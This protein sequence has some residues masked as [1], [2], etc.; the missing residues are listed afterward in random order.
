MRSHNSY[1]CKHRKIWQI[2]LHAKHTISVMVF[3]RQVLFQYCCFS[4]KHSF[5]ARNTPISSFQMFLWHFKPQKLLLLFDLDHQN[6]QMISFLKNTVSLQCKASTQV[7][8]LLCCSDDE[9]L[10]H[11]GEAILILPFPDMEERFTHTVLH[12]ITKRRLQGEKLFMH[13]IFLT[14]L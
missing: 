10:Q 2:A 9:V 4:M 8:L 13:I 6:K 5:T 11:C 7:F 1:V 3:K 12:F 14:K